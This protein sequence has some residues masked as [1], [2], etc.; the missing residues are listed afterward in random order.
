[1]ITLYELPPGF[2]LPVSVS[3]YCAKVELYF[4]LTGQAYDKAMGDLRK[5]PNKNVPYVKWDDGTIT[6]DSDAI[7]ARLEGDGGLDAGLAPEDKVRGAAAAQL[8][9]RVLYFAVLH[10]RFVDPAGWAHQKALVKC[11]VPALLS[12]ILVPIIRNSQVKR[13]KENGFGSASS[14]A[15]GVE[16]AATLS[17]EI[18]DK[19]FLLGDEPRTADCAVWANVMQAAYS[20]ASNPPRETVRNDPRLMAYIQ[21][22]ADRANLTMPPLQ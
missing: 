20:R 14:Y 3:P 19:P 7:I 15:A 17:K 12:P 10:A 1:V 8:A 9:Q 11:L 22:L 5:S 4:R 21:R 13:C 2:D 6:A 18:G 16:A